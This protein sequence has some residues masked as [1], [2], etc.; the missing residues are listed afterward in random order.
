[1]EKLRFGVIGGG[2]AVRKALPSLQRHPRFTLLGVV[3]DPAELRD[4]LP[5]ELRMGSPHELVSRRDIELVYIATPNDTHV[6]LAKLALEAGKHVLIEKPLAL[7]SRQASAVAQAAKDHLVVAV[8]FKKRFGHGIKE[9]QSFASKRK[10]RARYL[11]HNVYPRPGW[12]HLKHR[13]GGGVIMDLGSHGFDLLVYLFGRIS[14]ISA[15]EI[16]HEADSEVETSALISLDFLCGAQADVDLAWGVGGSCQSI[17]LYSAQDEIR[18]TRLSSD[19]DR[20]ELHCGPQLETRL[21]RPDA[22]YERMFDEL[23]R[24]IRQGRS[25]MTQLQDG[26]QNIELIEAVYR[27]AKQNDLLNL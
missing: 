10:V 19:E 8:A 9:L 13:A 6:P 14:R 21:L 24:Q 3:C 22:E 23:W 26:I 1:M 15:S 12:R 5:S 18:L 7:S 2:E 16:V 11:W 17:T 4:M 20:L 25:S 27:A